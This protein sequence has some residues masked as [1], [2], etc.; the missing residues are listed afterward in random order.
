MRAP[1]STWSKATLCAWPSDVDAQGY[2]PE[3]HARLVGA[4]IAAFTPAFFERVGSFGLQTERPVFI[5]GLPRSGTT[6][7]EQILAG[8]PQV[9]A[10]GELSLAHE[11]FEML[12]ESKE[13]VAERIGRLDAA[14][15]RAV[16]Q[17]HLD[18]LGEFSTAAL[19]VADKMPENYLYLGLLA[20]LFPRAKFI[21][22]RRDLRDVAVSCWMTDFTQI[23]WSNHPD[24]IVSRFQQY[25]RLMEH[26]RRV[27]PVPLLEIAYE[28]T[29]ADVE[30]AA[31]RL[32][33]WC[34][35]EWEPACLEFYK[36][37]GSVRTASVR[38]VR[39]PI[40]TRSVARWKQYQQT[41]APL[42]SRFA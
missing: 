34:G 13:G 30:A 5:T 38:Q 35:L 17:R 12:G 36:A 11:D 40:Y 15:I 18:Q 21:H 37:K 6:L 26:W 1:Q 33:D 31:R 3:S 4:T 2:D 39:Q 22:C 20:T 14:A 29:V 25:Q 28:E 32:V 24:H 10:A 19:R 23:R 16:A 42:L 8:H 27:L 41:L 7:I 9:F